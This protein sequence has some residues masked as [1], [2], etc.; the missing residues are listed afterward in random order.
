M[1]ARPLLSGVKHWDMFDGSCAMR[2][3]GGYEHIAGYAKVA[4]LRSKMS[5]LRPSTRLKLQLCHIERSLD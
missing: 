4:V 3:G 5:T 1:V 2:V